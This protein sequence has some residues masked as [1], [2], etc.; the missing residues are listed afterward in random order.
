MDTGSASHS[1][2]T[3]VVDEQKQPVILRGSVP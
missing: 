1:S 3:A 2:A